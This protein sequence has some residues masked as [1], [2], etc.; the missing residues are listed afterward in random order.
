MYHV[1]NIFFTSMN[2]HLSKNEAEA[3]LNAI[4]NNFIN[5]FFFT[6]P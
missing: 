5:N 3:E 1:F 6:D 2:F 4:A